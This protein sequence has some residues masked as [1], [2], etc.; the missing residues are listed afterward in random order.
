MKQLFQELQRRKVYVVGAAYLVVSW[1]LLQV[2]A[3]VLPI[4]DTPN[5]VLKVFTTLLALGFPVALLLAWAYELTPQGVRRTDDPEPAA[6]STDKVLEM[7]K[8]PTI[9]VLPFRNLTNDPEQALFAQAITEDIV[10][11][12]TLGTGL[13]VVATGA[14]G[15]DTDPIE[16]ARELGVR[17]LLTG[18]VNRSGDQ[19][20]VTARLSDTSKQQEIWSGSYDEKLSAGKLFDIQDDI[21]EQIVATLGDFHGV[22]FSSATRQNL[23]RPTDSL[24]AYQCLAVALAYDKTLSEQDHLRARDSLEHA[25]ELD[26]EFDEAWSHLSWIYT[27]EEVYGYNQKPDAMSRALSVAR[28]AIEINPDNYHSHWLLARVYYFKGDRKRY[29]ASIERSLALNASDGTTIGLIGGYLALAGEWERGLALLAK[30]RKLNPR[31]P[32]YYYMYQALAYLH[33][34][35]AEAA[36]RELLRMGLHGWPVGEAVTAAACAMVGDDEGA[37][38]YW[39]SARELAGW[40][41]SGDALVP[42]Q[43]FLPFQPGLLESIGIALSTIESPRGNSGA[44]A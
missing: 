5:W 39:A 25:I 15:H 7:P 31:F 9:S 1:L 4:Y 6:L 37:Q 44:C 27:D 40:Q 23:N 3:T 43:R 28:R 11:G 22:V 33:D 2:A 42:L 12:L 8:G 18:S 16:A 24:S 34:G 29:I 38:R 41:E 19:L 36:H 14:L 17:H 32:D 10:R 30:A 26:P 35:D 13:S 21:R 20:R